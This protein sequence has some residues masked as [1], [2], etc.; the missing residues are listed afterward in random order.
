M[1]KTAANLVF[2]EFQGN[3]MI[4]L[5]LFFFVYI[6]VWI[7]LVI[8][9]G[10]VSWRFS[11]SKKVTGIA[12]VV[13]FF[14]MYWPAFGDYFSTVNAHKAYCEKEAGFKI[15]VTPEQW[16][17]EN[18]GVLET[19]V[20]YEKFTPYD[21]GELGNDRFA[22][23]FELFPM[24]N[25]A[26]QKSVEKLLD[27]KT[28]EVLYEGIDFSRGYEHYN[29]K[30]W[31]HIKIWLNSPSCFTYQDLHEKSILK[32]TYFKKLNTRWSN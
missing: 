27:I 21:Q 19:L 22:I 24:D 12:S 28:N 29:S 32:N 20:P 11:K 30:D 14:V 26:V 25:F 4:L 1:A 3:F 17:A 10:I 31:R 15:Y 23:K 7:A 6:A 16:A 9:V 13:A 18:P 5:P 2:S 8:G